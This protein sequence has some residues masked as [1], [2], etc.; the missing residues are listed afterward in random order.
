[1]GLGLALQ[2]VPR[3]VLLYCREPDS[4]L[5]LTKFC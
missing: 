3:E 2:F 4:R 5:E 1:M